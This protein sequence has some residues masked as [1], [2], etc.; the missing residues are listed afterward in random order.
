MAAATDTADLSTA[1]KSTPKKSE[2]KSH[3]TKKKKPHRSSSSS[4]GSSSGEEDS[5]SSSSIGKAPGPDKHLHRNS[6]DA[7]SKQHG[8]HTKPKYS[9]SVTIDKD[10]EDSTSKKK[11]AEKT[12]KKY[13]PEDDSTPKK[14]GDKVK[15]YVPEDDSD[16]EDEYEKPNVDKPD[17]EKPRS[18]APADKKDDNWG[19]YDTEVIYIPGRN[20]KDGVDGKDGADGK[21]RGAGC[22]ACMERNIRLIVLAMSVCAY[23]QS[24]RW[25]FFVCHVVA[26]HV[27]A[28]A[29]AVPDGDGK[30]NQNWSTFWMRSN[31][32]VGLCCSSCGISLLSAAPTYCC[33]RLT[34]AAAAA[35]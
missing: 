8:K 33:C 35:A 15:K 13:V 18:K 20:G 24:R 7:S 30:V 34:A 9:F 2:S 4:S 25:Y 10:I 17:V 1:Y 32:T 12:T 3:P 16:A 11:Y 29:V 5:E 26:C 27:R 22:V 19:E 6:K 23:C 14:T 28:L 31:R 21:V